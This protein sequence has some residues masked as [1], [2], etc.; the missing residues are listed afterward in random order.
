M[1]KEAGV[2]GYEMEGFENRYRHT[3]FY[4]GV[5]YGSQHP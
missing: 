3:Y 1:N 2:I 5:V 4:G